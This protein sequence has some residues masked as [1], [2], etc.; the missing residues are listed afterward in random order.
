MIDLSN[1]SRH[2]AL[3]PSLVQ[4]NLIRKLILI[5][6]ESKIDSKKILKKK[7]RFFVDYCYSFNKCLLFMLIQ[8]LLL[9]SVKAFYLKLLILAFYYHVVR[10]I[11][12]Y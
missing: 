12:I 2:I 7:G 10:Y 6:Y 8:M 11:Y 9:G 4:T 3:T 5:K 1:I